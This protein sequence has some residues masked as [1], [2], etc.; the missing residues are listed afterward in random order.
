[1]VRG[2]KLPDRPTQRR[3][4]DM[5]SIDPKR[6]EQSRRIVRHILQRIRN[7]RLLPLDHLGHH[8][9]DIGRSRAVELLRQPHVAIVV[10]NDRYPRDVRISMNS[11]GQRVN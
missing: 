2:D 5:R 9:D 10:A 6:I 11:N 4:H 8:L 1:M 7:A 3:A